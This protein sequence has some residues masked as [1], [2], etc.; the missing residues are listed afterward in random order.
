M[1]LSLSCALAFSCDPCMMLIVNNEE[2]FCRYDKLPDRSSNFSSMMCSSE[3]LYVLLK[4]D[5]GFDFA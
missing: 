4:Y 5:I 2:Y 3:A 1:I